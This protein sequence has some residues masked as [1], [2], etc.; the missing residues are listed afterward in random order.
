MGF[1]TSRIE[2]NAALAVIL[3]ACGRYQSL[4]SRSHRAGGKHKND[5]SGTRFAFNGPCHNSRCRLDDLA[6]SNRVAMRNA[7]QDSPAFGVF[8]PPF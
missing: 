3:A 5:A 8:G 1:F 7:F 2:L 4:D 6:D